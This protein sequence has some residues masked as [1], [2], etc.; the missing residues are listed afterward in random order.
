[1]RACNHPVQGVPTKFCAYRYRARREANRIGCGLPRIA[2]CATHLPAPQ[3]VDSIDV[4]RAAP[5]RADAQARTSGHRDAR[6]LR[7]FRAVD[8]KNH[9]MN[10]A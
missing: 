1:M 9:Y 10:R 8:S 4:C 5:L 6:A 2:H 7:I 3:H